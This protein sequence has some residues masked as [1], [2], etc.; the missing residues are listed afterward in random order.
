MPITPQE[1]HREVGMMTDLR[2]HAVGVERLPTDLAGIVRVVQGLLLHE[3]WA[4]A[5]GFEVPAERR[6][7]VSIRAAARMLDVVFELDPA[8]LDRA[9]PVERRMLGNCRDFTT[10]TCALLKR[11]G[12]AARARCGFGAYFRPGSFEDHWVCEYWH[13]D[14]RRWIL[15]DAQLDAL[16]RDSLKL[17]FD[18][19]DVPREQFW[20]AGQAWQRCRSGEYDPQ[21]FG[22][23]EMRGSWFVN[24]NVFRDLAALNRVEL[25]PWD[26]WGL[27]ERAFDSYGADELALVDRMAALSQAGDAEFDQVRSLYASDAR[28]RVPNVITSL[29]PG[30]EPERVELP[31]Y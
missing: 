13:P 27:L 21:R 7:E 8:P 12:I 1:F 16:Q 26:V 23:F 9:R 15:A 28:I 31:G 19:L 30:R 18:A 20:V 29:T 24:G 14:D 2:R 4:P 22:I 6:S 25:L 5:Y 10:L 11:A 3:H 17:Q